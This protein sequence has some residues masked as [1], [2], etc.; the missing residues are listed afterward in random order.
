MTPEILGGL[1]V[2]TVT[3]VILVILVQIVYA[4]L[5]LQAHLGAWIFHGKGSLLMK[6]LAFILWIPLTLFSLVV[7]IIGV[8]C[9]VSL[10]KDAKK[11]F[12]R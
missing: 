11:W 3:A 6:L 12:D 7:G 10:A 8:L 9:A 4:L 2:M 5:G 1:V